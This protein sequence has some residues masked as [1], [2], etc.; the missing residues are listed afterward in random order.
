MRAGLH[1]WI[2][3]GS[4]LAW[5]ACDGDR[6]RADDDGSS[7]SSNGTGA[8]SG[9]C[10]EGAACFGEGTT[11]TDDG[12]CPCVYEC[13]GG[14]WVQQGCAGCA[15]PGCPSEPPVDGAPCDLCSTQPE[16]SYEQCE[17]AG[18]SHAECAPNG[19]NPQRM[20]T[21]IAESCEPA[22]PCGA[23]PTAAACPEGDVCVIAEITVGPSSMTT[24]SCAP[25]P[26]SPF[27]TSCDCAQSLCVA[28]DAPLCVDAT[29]RTIHCNNGA[30]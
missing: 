4:V 20:W 23:E 12:C 13:S 15:Q 24:Y 14:Q 30:Q 28:A 8:S 3:L 22:P 26:C 1:G 10:V 9:G 2:L 29:P 5:M 16:C 17:G 7:S 18:M 27:V 25:N 21:V 11:C 6:N 19:D